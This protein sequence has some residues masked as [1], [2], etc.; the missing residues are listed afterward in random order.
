MQGRLLLN[1]VVREGTAVFQLLSGEDQ[2]LLVRRN[3]F[4]ILD[5][6]LDIVDGIA[7]FD[8]KSDGLSGQ[9]LNEKSAWWRG[10]VVNSSSGEMA[11]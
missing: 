11:E 9:S 10:E 5:L 4:L 6:G 7:G 1:V 2:T 3:A 8:L